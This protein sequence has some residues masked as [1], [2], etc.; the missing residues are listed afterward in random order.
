[1]KKGF[2]FTLDAL[3]AVSVLAVFLAVVSFELNVPKQTYWLPELGNTFMTSL[4]KSGV[5]YGIYS[6][7]SGA[8][9]TLTY[10]LNTLPPNINAKIT[11]TIYSV[12]SGDVFVPST[13]IEISKGTISQSQETHIKR[14]FSDITSKKFGIAELVLSYA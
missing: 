9:S 11:V 10:Y 2:I 4:D 6:N 5:L 12:P 3:F 8:Q 7:P 1:M 13:P 14:V